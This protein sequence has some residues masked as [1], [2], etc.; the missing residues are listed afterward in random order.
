MISQVA[1]S[2][3]ATVVAH[4]PER[5]LLL[6]DAGALALSK[7]AAP[8]G[9]FG[10]VLGC[11]AVIDV[12]CQIYCSFAASLG[13]PIVAH[14]IRPLTHLQE[15]P[16]CAGSVTGGCKGRACRRPGD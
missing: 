13:D 1:V 12:K 7:D 2:V 5:N 16:C 8:D 9:F 10:S 3:L 14:A 6:C 11:V 4:Y 15:R